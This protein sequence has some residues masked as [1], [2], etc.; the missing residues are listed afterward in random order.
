MEQSQKSQNALFQVYLR[1]RPP[2]PGQAVSERF[3]T[4]E[5][6]GDDAP[7]T[8][9][10]LNPP[11]DNRRRAVEKFAFTEVFEEDSNQLDLF[12]GTG[13]LPLVEGVLGPQGGEGRD[14]LLATLGVTGSGKSHTILG[15]RTQRGLTQLALDV[16]F[17]SI[18]NNIL[19]PATTT[20]LHATVAASDPSEAQVM[21]SQMF[22]D[23]MYGDPTAASRASSRAPTPMVGESYA[24]PPTPRRHLQR[25]SALPIVPDISNV[26]V[27]ADSNAEYAILISMYEVYNDRIFDLLTPAIPN[28][29]TKDFRRR[30]LLFKSTEQSPDRKV[31]AGLRKIICGT[32][33]EA[34]M[35]LEAGL[36]ERR[37]A[38]TG[39][40]SVSSR[41]HGFFCVEV[42]KR[43]RSRM[44]T[45]WGGSALTIV[46]LAGS[47]RARDAKTQG[48]T[49]A[50]AGKINESLMYLGQCLQMQ[51][52]LG[53]STKPNLVPF[54]QCKLTELLFSN[55][56]PSTSHQS[57]PSTPS[58]HHSSQQ[59]RNP[60]KAVM[61]VTADPLG[62]FNATSQILRYSALAREITVPRIPSVT[63]TILAQSTASHYFSPRAGRMSPTDT[64][65]ETMEIAALEIARM[66]E[67]IDGL[68]AE[69]LAEQQQRLEV[70]AH[71]ESMTDRIMEVEAEVR[72]ECFSEMEETMEAEMRRWKASWAQEQDK[73]EEHIDRKLEIYTRSI[74]ACEEDKENTPVRDI[75]LESE[76]ER[77]RREVEILRREVQGRSPSKGQR[78]PLRDMHVGDLGSQMEKMRVSGGSQRVASGGSPVKKVRK[79]TAKKWD[80]MGEDDDL[81]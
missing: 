76:N 12:H 18:S 32:M 44:P 74:D 16:L 1:L 15:S 69:L 77:L 21:S 58:H 26:T 33:K 43:R 46:D 31:V 40:N 79:L 66:S 73:S 72:E 19:D 35:V 47:E 37:V 6:P 55:S 60:Q 3:L 23:T 42:K 65:R 67:E 75:S 56:F 80:M 54:R 29:S 5:E 34:L 28:K 4:V 68:R 51:S 7:P 38:G 62:D 10:T 63:S 39:S 71:L 22:L 11:N 78:A 27:D 2:P 8:H 14:G 49:L 59:P 24:P 36:H 70:E 17:R 13:V 50:E 20:S 30:P 45:Q 81:L 57:V 41:S 61:I 53:N 48:A 64:E 9:I 25:P 52:D